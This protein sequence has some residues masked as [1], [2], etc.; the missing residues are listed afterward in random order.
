MLAV[1]SDG[2]WKIAP[3]DYIV[4]LAE[5]SDKPLQKVTVHLQGREFAAGAKGGQ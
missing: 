2:K 1:F 3:G 5:A 4:T